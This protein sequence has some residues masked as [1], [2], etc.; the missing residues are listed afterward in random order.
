M[1]VSDQIVQGNAVPRLLGPCNA[2]APGFR[3]SG[4][5]SGRGWPRCPAGRT[6]CMLMAGRWEVA[7]QVDRRAGHAHRRAG[8]RRRSSTADLERAVAVATS[9]GAY[10]VLLTAPCARTR[11]AAER[12]ALAGG[13]ALRDASTTTRSSRQVAADHPHNVEVDDFGAAGVP[14]W[15]LHDDHATAYAS[16]SPTGCTSRECPVATVPVVPAAKWLAWKLL[17]RGG[18]S[19]PAAD[20]RDPAAMSPGRHSTAGA[21]RARPPAHGRGPGTADH[22]RLRARPRRAAGHR[23]A[24]GHALPRGCSRGRRGL[25]RQSTSSSCSR[26]SSSPRSC[27]ASGPRRLTVRLGQFWARRARR[28]LPALLVHAGRGGRLRQGLRHPGGV[29]QPAARLALDAVLRRQLALHLRR[30]PTTS[31]RPLSV[32]ARA[33]VVALDRGAVLHRVA[34]GGTGVA[35]SRGGSSARAGG[36]GRSSAVAVAGAIASAV[37]MR[38][39]SCTAPRSRAST[40]A[41]T[42]AVRTSWS[43]RPWPSRWPCGPSTG[44]RR[45]LERS[46]RPVGR[47]LRARS[48]RRSAPTGAVAAAATPARSPPPP[49]PRASGRSPPGRSARPRARRPPGHRLVAALPP[50]PTSG[51]G[52]PGRARSSSR[53]ATS[54]SRSGW[55]WSSSAW[56]PHRPPRCRAPSATR[57]SATSARSPTA[58][59][60]GTSRCSPSSTPARLHLYGYPLL[61]VRIGVTLVVATGSYYLVEEP[62]RRGR[63]RSFTEWRAWLLTSCA[64][65]GVVAVTVATTLPVG[66]RGR[67]H[68]SGWSAPSTPDRRCKVAI[69]GD[70]VAWRLGLR[71]AGQP[72]PERLRREHRQRRDRRLR[73]CSGAPST[74]LTASPIRSVPRATRRSPASRPVAGAVEGRPRP[75]RSQRGRRAGR[76]VGGLGPADRRPVAPHRRA[77]IRRRSQALARAGGAGRD[78]E[79]RLDGADDLAVLRLGRADQRAAV[80]GGLA[81]PPRALQPDGPP[82]GRRAPGHRAARRLRRPVVPGRRTSPRR[83][84]GVQ[85]RDGDGV[86]IV[87]TRC[88][89]PVARCARPARRGRGRASADGR[90]QPGVASTTSTTVTPQPAGRPPVA[91]PDSCQ[92][93]RRSCH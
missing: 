62:I 14:R 55:P 16:D 66:R 27:S 10:L 73:A 36:C 5:R 50:V 81:R 38:L 64:F 52:S 19:R 56:S 18:A 49:R 21:R 26:A 45:K 67:R 65:L 92:W 42:P 29:R 12:A 47:A 91:A 35:P 72:A 43:V 7:D 59:T 85:I 4:R 53:A 93:R 46:R 15:H 25:P 23:G 6:S 11:R 24:R 83:S 17:P 74:S 71:H 1:V 90:A 89:R 86:H 33:H 32:A 30:R 88:G 9:T 44:P 61:A 37:D 28:L 68:R 8:L 41:P 39:S 22:L 34:A 63:I 20:D 76:P 31:T 78:L 75:V 82:G 48:T 40:R 69:F 58:P 87:P 70:S 2:S 54:S 80:A 13:L 51:R 3:S 77:G 60:S 79:R 57:S 84:T